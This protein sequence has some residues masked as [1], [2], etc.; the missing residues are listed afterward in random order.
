MPSPLGGRRFGGRGGGRAK[1]VER[2]ENDDGGAKFGQ[3]VAGGVEA[4]G[5]GQEAVEVPERFGEVGGDGA[6]GQGA[7]VDG[8]GHQ[9]KE[10]RGAP[11]AGYAVDL[12]AVTELGAGRRPQGDVV[13]GEGHAAGQRPLASGRDEAALPAARGRDRVVQRNRKR[14]CAALVVNSTEDGERNHARR[15]G[16]L[17]DGAG[18]GRTPNGR[19]RAE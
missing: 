13:C 7:P 16:D 15:H 2:A 14:D 3:G 10:R 17:R 1:T 19:R 12:G 9:V 18:G 5:V 8:I 11:G 4:V 6:A